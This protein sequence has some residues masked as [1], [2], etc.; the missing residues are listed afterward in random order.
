[1]RTCLFLLISFVL[2]SGS[3]QAQFNFGGDAP[4]LID[5]ETATYKNNIT[6]LTGNVD[7][8]QGDAQ[9][10]SDEM[11]I[12]RAPNS[13]SPDS[14]IG[15]VTRIEAT[16]NFEY[17]TPDNRVTGNKGV[18]VRQSGKITVTGD[19]ALVQPSGSRVRGEKLTYFIET[20]SAKFGDECVGEGCNG[21][22]TFD[23]KQ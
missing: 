16:G 20:K 14:A 1:M 2:F 11:K 7:V 10:L 17:I 12:Y 9:I 15:V 4:I 6:I 22:V 23:I 19:V 21:R 5:A 18:Y 8:R 3:A 13:D